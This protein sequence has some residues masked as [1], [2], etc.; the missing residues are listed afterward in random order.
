MSGAPDDHRDQ[1][2]QQRADRIDVHDRVQRHA[3]EPPRRVVA[4]LARRPRMR[5][6]VNRQRKHQN[7]EGDD[8][9]REV[10]VR[11][12]RVESITGYRPCREVCK[13]GIGSFRA[14]HGRQLFARRA[15]HA[16]QAA[17]R[18]EQRLPPPRT[19]AGHAVELRPQIAHR[20]RLAMERDGE[21]VRFVANPLQEQQRRIVFRERDRLFAIARVEQL[22]LLGDADRDEIR[23][24]QLLERVVG[25]RQLPLPPSIRMRSG[26]GPPCSSSLR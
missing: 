24:P 10:D 19:D 21:P 17:E 8:E 12:Q 13:D 20:P 18:H 23:E 7:Q 16:R 9:S 4:E 3:S 22:F 26:N 25:R 5:R 2:E 1:R 6:L 11:Q 15:P 14:D